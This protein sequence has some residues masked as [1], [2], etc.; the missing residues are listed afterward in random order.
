MGYY[1]HGYEMDEY[2]VELELLD[3]QGYFDVEEEM[4]EDDDE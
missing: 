3:E 4:E 2:D 1:H